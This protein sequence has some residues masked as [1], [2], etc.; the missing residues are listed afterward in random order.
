MHEL[1]LT[2]CNPEPLADYLKALGVLRLVAEQAGG[3][4]RGNWQNNGFVLS[5][6]LDRTSLLGFFTERY[7]PTPILAAWNGG[8]G[9]F[10]RRGS[11]DPETGKA[12]F[13]KPTEMTRATDAIAASKAS[14]LEPIRTF[15]HFCQQ[16]V[17]EQGLET[18][19]KPDEKRRLLATLR[20]NADDQ[21]LAWLDAVVMVGERDAR[22]PPLLG[23]GGN[24]GALDFANNLHRRLSEI[25]DVDTGAPTE[26]SVAWLDGALFGD[27]VPGLVSAAVGQYDPASAGGANR[28]EGFGV[29]SSIVNPWD[30]ILMMEGALVLA[31]AATRRME[32]STGG[33]LSYPFTVRTTGA[34][35]ASI[36]E[37]DGASSASRAEIWLPLWS[38]PAAWSEVQRLFAEGRA[39]VGRRPA[40]DA[41]DFAR[42]LGTLGVDRGVSSF[43]RYGFLKRNGLAYF[44]TPLGRWTVQRRT[45]LDLIS[46]ALDRWIAQSRREVSGSESPATQRAAGNVLARS[47]LDLGR[48]KQ[49]PSQVQA[50]LVALAN[51]E[52]VCARSPS[53]RAKVRPV[54]PLPKRWMDRAD[55]GSPEYRLARSLAES[56]LRRRIAVL[57]L[58]RRYDWSARNDPGV[59]WRRGLL[60]DALIAVIRRQAVEL[61]MVRVAR[62]QAPELAMEGLE[63]K[64]GGAEALSDDIQR[65]LNAELDDEKIASLAEAL[66]LV[67]LQ[68]KKT[69]SIHPKVSQLPIDP[70]WAMAA[71]AWDQRRLDSSDDANPRRIQGLIASGTKG[72][73]NALSRT[74]MRRL[75]SGTLR[76]ER[77]ESY[78]SGDRGIPVGTQYATPSRTRRVIASLAFPLADRTLVSLTSVVFGRESSDA[79]TV[80]TS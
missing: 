1:V 39:T 7:S 47:L 15:V 79:I 66:S 78:A 16:A 14:R 43:V 71:L 24:D 34:G 53:L 42:A 54:P 60:V 45:V 75:Q 26:A 19:P 25:M 72:D 21:A 12:R 18:V 17:Q 59:V 68:P 37:T 2:G 41:V 77:G 48:G 46:P 33:A 32:S 70:L 62:S 27:P 31:S 4:V 76:H 49:Q 28:N 35:A 56:D 23:T 55:D 10:M 67:G 69:S 11:K 3:E 73:A 64:F 50:V 40:V 44:A 29:N 9:L 36:A 5:S 8:G 80:E 51:L 20:D 58:R 30:F 74:A 52:A 6:P 57:E 63:P 13:D 38:R 22:F 65:F 61:S